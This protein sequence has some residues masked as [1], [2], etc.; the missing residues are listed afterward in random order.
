MANACFIFRRDL[1]I[2][3]N[4]ALIEATKKYKKITCVFIMTPEQLK[5]NIYKSE[6][7]IQFMYEC[8]KELNQKIVLNFFYGKP[9][10]II[11]KILKENPS[12]H[13]IYVNQDYTW[14]S[15]QRDNDIKQ[16]CEKKNVLFTS[17]EDH[18]LN[19]V[20]IVKTTN[21]KYYSIFTPYY[22]KA[23]SYKIKI[24][25]NVKHKNFI[26]IKTNS[27]LEKLK[28]FFVE[29]KNPLIQGGRK[30][31]LKQFQDKK[32]DYKTK[33]DNLN[34]TTT[35]L[36]A[37]IKFG[38][39]SIREVYYNFKGNETLTRQLYWHDFYTTLGFHEIEYSKQ[40]SRIYQP[41]QNISWMNNDKWELWK[42]GKTGFPIVDA[43]MR[44]LNSENYC[45]NRGRL[46][47]SG[48]IKFM[49]MDWKQA[50]IYYAKQLRDYSPS[51]NHYN[52]NWSMSFGP[53]STPYFRI[54]NVFTQGKKHD[55][56]GEY[57]KK[58][59]PELKDVPAKDIHKWNETYKNHLN[60]NYP[61][62]IVDYNEQRD[63]TMKAYKKIFS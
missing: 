59:I 7:A 9:T 56:N 55:P 1:R 39:V 18:L 60:I 34:Y 30:E 26:K 24:P 40:N 50:E 53:F 12:I 43:C 46:I 62:P 25:E 2:F 27:S 61:K 16:I 35:L 36:S 63:K 21:N 33:R 51:A 6:S 41:K 32:K 31:A 17:Y 28:Q 19:N 54:M 13:E 58:W 44:Q 42:Q 5:N 10:S 38:C 29:N 15:Q 3:D 22:K 11:S 47:V 8:L 49:F 52:W 14:Y 57:I 20:N 37:F 48:F 23:K 45:H 4:T